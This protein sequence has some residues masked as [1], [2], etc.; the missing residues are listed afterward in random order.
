MQSLP[1]LARLDLDI[2]SLVQDG[3][4]FTD[5]K[6]Q[7]W[8]E[9]HVLHTKNFRVIGPVGTIILEGQTDL[10]QESIDMQAVVVPNVDISGATIAAG[11]ALNP[12][13]GISAFL[14]QFVLKTPLAKAMTVNY[15]LSGTWEEIEIKDGKK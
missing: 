1:R 11:I 3:F 15:Q 4:P 12:V 9:Q 8:L 14:T 13:I 2:G 6:G 7:L 10:Q 5:I